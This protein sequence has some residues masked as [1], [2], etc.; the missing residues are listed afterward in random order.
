[1]T[2]SLALCTSINIGPSYNHSVII[3]SLK[4]DSDSMCCSLQC[5]HKNSNYIILKFKRRQAYILCKVTHCTGYATLQG[6]TRKW[7]PLY[8]SHTHNTTFS[9][10]LATC[11]QVVFKYNKKGFLN[12]ECSQHKNYWYKKRHICN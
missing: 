8:I 3:K 4:H 1:M 9:F 12:R 5:M 6:V 11:M 7:G 2:S 10:P